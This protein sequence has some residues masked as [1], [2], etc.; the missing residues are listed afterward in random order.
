MPLDVPVIT[1]EREFE[2]APVCGAE[3]SVVHFSPPRP[4]VHERIERRARAWLGGPW[5]AEIQQI[6]AAGHAPTA[7]GLGVLGYPE[8]LASLRGELPEAE[9]IE[10]VIIAT[11][12]YARQQE[13]WF[14]KEDAAARAG[15]A[16]GLLQPLQTLLEEAAGRLG[17]A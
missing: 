3:L 16:A 7:P 12:R 14:R 8:V 11:R 2:P 5:Q 17:L 15:D 6:L 1:T 4:L 9:L 10:R 13:T